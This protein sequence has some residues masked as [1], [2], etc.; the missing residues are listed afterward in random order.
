MNIQPA[1]PCTLVVFGASGDLFKRLLLPALYNLAE[2]GLLHHHFALVGIGRSKLSS[3]EFQQQSAENLQRYGTTSI[4]TQVWQQL[5]ANFHYL[6]GSFE[7]QATYEYLVELLS[8]VNT[9]SRTSGNY[10]FYLATAPDYFGA[11][12]QRLAASGLT[13]E[14]DGSWRRVII[15]KP[16]GRDLASAR[17]LNCSI[18]S[19]LEEQQIYRI[20]HYLGKE[21][22]QN[23]LVLRFANSIFEPLWNSK[24]ISH[25]QITWW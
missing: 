25:I 14:K 16:F 1:E 6:D 9:K 17:A 11:I 5:G 8:E 24:Y 18:R 13:I 19:V 2:R 10:L 7:E 4:D 21:T 23:I 22:V 12:V 20:D 3:E 15:E